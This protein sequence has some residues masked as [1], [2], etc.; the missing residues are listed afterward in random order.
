ME[1]AI[2][3]KA[4]RKID[5]VGQVQ[6]VTRNGLAAAENA[7]HRGRDTKTSQTR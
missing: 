5:I 7:Q 1:A 2:I 4:A 3:G 6:D